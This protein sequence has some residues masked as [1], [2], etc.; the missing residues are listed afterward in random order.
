MTKP[1]KSAGEKSAERLLA[2]I[3]SGGQRNSSKRSCLRNTGDV[4]TL[5][6]ADLVTRGPSGDLVV[7]AAGR[8]HLARANFAQNGAELDPF[9]AQHVTLA[10]REVDTAAGRTAVAVNDAE[11]PLIWLARRKGRDGQ[12]LIEPIQLQAGER[13]RSEFTRAQLMPRTTS[14][15]SA[16][17]AGGRRS[18]G[19]GEATFTEAIIAARQRVRRAL[20]VVGPEFAGLLLDVCCFL[21]G[22]EDVE[23]ERAWPARSAKIVLQLALDRLG[24]HYGFASEARGPERASIRTWLAADAAFFVGGD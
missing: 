22:L 2:G 13:L 18:S 20:E 6:S 14:N 4:S 19:V 7:T 10:R 3:A 15:W 12:P 1:N 8:A 23:R 17:G 21:K 11:S 5:I 16:A 9:L 24:R